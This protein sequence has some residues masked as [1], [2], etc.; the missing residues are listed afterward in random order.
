MIRFFYFYNKNCLQSLEIVSFST[1]Q[2]KMKRKR[3]ILKPSFYQGNINLE[4][5]ICYIQ[6]SKDLPTILISLTYVRQALLNLNN[7]VYLSSTLTI[8]CLYNFQI[9]M[10]M[11]PF[12]LGNS[13][14][15]FLCVVLCPLPRKILLL[16]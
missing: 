11:H 9:L 5:Q 13:K 7:Q 2:T 10:V 8:I 3:F 16:L 4:N 6:V 14:E 1:R 15:C 12:S